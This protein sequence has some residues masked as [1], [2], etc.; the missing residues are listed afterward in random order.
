MLAFYQFNGEIFTGLYILTESE[1]PFTDTQLTKWLKVAG[2]MAQR[3][4]GKA[5]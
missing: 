2:T 4:Q 5:V 3:L 1:T